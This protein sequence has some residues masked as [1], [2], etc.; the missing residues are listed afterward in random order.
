[1]TSPYPFSE[2]LDR[3]AA[4]VEAQ[5]CHPG[6]TLPGVWALGRSPPET[7]I[8][9]I[10]SGALI[11]VCRQVDYDKSAAIS[12]YLDLAQHHVTLSAG[13]APDVMAARHLRDAAE[14]MRRLEA[15]VAVEKPA[16]VAL[17][18]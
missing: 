2:V 11:R 18:R 6:Q 7:L 15:G 13:G 1:M 17:P 5:P 16:A 3:A 8:G 12:R 4:D 9:I 10:A 14:A